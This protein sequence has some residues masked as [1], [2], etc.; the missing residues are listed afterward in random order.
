MHPQYWGGAGVDTGT[1]IS[2]PKQGM[3]A[4]V[5]SGTP[6]NLMVE[7][8]VARHPLFR[9]HKFDVHQDLDVDFVDMIL[10]TTLQ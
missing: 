9:R 8:T 10:G 1:V 2:V 3:P 6:G 5:K 7:L 4:Q